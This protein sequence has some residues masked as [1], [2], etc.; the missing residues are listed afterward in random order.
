MSGIVLLKSHVKSH[1]RKLKDGGVTR[2]RERDD[3]RDE[4]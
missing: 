1:L 4:A 3:R 2:V